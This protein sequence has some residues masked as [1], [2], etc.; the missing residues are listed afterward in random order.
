[1]LGII[2][3]IQ[4]VLQPIKKNLME[5]CYIDNPYFSV[6]QAAE[7]LEQMEIHLMNY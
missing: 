5:A 7:S 2:D 1:M 3:G 6:A 4:P